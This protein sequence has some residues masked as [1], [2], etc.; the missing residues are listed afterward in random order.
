MTT[1]E[2]VRLRNALYEA[3]EL[4]HQA[5]AIDAQTELRAYLYLRVVYN[6]FVTA[7]DLG[8]SRPKDGTA[9]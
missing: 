7:L 6:Q 2:R 5:H 9:S 3:M 1:A 8:H 4:V